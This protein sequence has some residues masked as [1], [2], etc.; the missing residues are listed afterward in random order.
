M[1]MTIAQLK[2]QK[3]RA[4]YMAR[5]HKPIGRRRANTVISP[6]HAALRG[7][8]N[9]KAMLD[10]A[11]QVVIES[12]DGDLEVIDACIE[13]LIVFIGHA[14]PDLDTAALKYLA[15]DLRKGKPLLKHKVKAAQQTL[16]DL[17][18]YLMHRTWDCV[19]D[20]LRISEIDIKLEALGLKDSQQ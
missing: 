4:R 15:S 6:M 20:A 14:A 1:P 8:A 9:G 16:T 18:N 10:D 2:V 7:L 17:E 5:L 11:G 19:R 13:G 3:E 12:S